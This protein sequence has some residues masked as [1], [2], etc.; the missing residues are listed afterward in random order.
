MDAGVGIKATGLALT[1]KLIPFTHE[2]IC[3]LPEVD[4]CLSRTGVQVSESGQ[5][6]GGAASA[7]VS[8]SQPALSLHLPS[9]KENLSLFP[10]VPILK[11]GVSILTHQ[12][13]RV[14]D[15]RPAP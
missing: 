9:F 7:K 8:F 2:S 5:D 3:V 15:A 4:A 12:G 14:V 11:Y 6:E 1:E 10:S 13:A